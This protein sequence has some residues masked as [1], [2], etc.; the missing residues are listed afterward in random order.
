[1]GTHR[2]LT[3][4]K[5]AFYSTHDERIER[6]KFVGREEKLMNI[7]ALNNKSHFTYFIATRCIL[8]FKFD[9][10]LIYQYLFTIEERACKERY[11]FSYI[12][13]GSDL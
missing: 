6:G 3:W 9:K 4:F 8:P 13:S 7:V 1:M 12:L 5:E 10:W 11:L 2:A